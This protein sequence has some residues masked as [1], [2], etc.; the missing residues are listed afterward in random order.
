MSPIIFLPRIWPHHLW[1]LGTW[2][3][4]LFPMPTVWLF[5]WLVNKL[6]KNSLL[7]VLGSRSSINT[8]PIIGQTKVHFLR[9]TLTLNHRSF[10]SLHLGRSW[11]NVEE[12]H[13]VELES[14]GLQKTSHGS[15]GTSAHHQQFIIW[16][17]S[18]WYHQIYLGNIFAFFS[19]LFFLVQ[20]CLASFFTSDQPHSSE[21]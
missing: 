15:F 18:L 14:W 13:N 9:L 11:S 3:F 2:R 6:L 19:L 12:K 1:S 21:K 17:I 10:S 16:N 4:P 20:K 8:S 5:G 7:E